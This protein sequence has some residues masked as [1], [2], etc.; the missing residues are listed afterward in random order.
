MSKQPLPNHILRLQTVPSHE[1]SVLQELLQQHEA[2]TQRLQQ[3]ERR[4][5]QLR[6]E[7][8]NEIREICLQTL[9]QLQGQSN[10]VDEILTELLALHA[11]DTEIQDAKQLQNDLTTALSQI[12]SLTQRIEALFRGEL[13]SSQIQA[14]LQEVLPSKPQ[15]THQTQP[16]PLS[17]KPHPLQRTTLDTLPESIVIEEPVPPTTQAIPTTEPPSLPEKATESSETPQ[18]STVSLFTEGTPTPKEE[19]ARQVEEAYKVRE[20]QKRE[21]KEQKREEKAQK[22]PERILRRIRVLKDRASFRTAANELIQARHQLSEQAWGELGITLAQKAN[23]ADIEQDQWQDFFQL[24]PF[25]KKAALSEPKLPEISKSQEIELTSMIARLKDFSFRLDVNVQ[26]D[27]PDRQAFLDKLTKILQH[28]A[29]APSDQRLLDIVEPFYVWIETGKPFRSLRRHL[30]EPQAENGL[31][32]T[33]QN[34]ASPLK[35]PEETGPCASKPN[36]TPKDDPPNAPLDQ[37][38]QETVKPSSRKRLKKEQKKQDK[39]DKQDKKKQRLLENLLHPEPNIPEGPSI[40][41]MSPED[42]LFELQHLLSGKRAAMIG[43]DPREQRRKALEDK[44]GFQHL[45]WIQ[46]ENSSSTRSTQELVRRLQRGKV[47]LLILLLDFC[48]HPKAD[49]LIDTAKKIGIPFVPVMHGYGESRILQALH[50]TLA[51]N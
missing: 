9:A 24:K 1:S 3:L 33:L 7:K 32:A 31:A 44:L 45:D 5:Q 29:S 49:A 23:A 51:S 35:I 17:N 46:S 22:A 40:Q 26:I 12:S 18:G 11:P 28:P 42:L 20:E 14:L 50:R 30:T 6:Q 27:H 47:D 36:A 10:Q 13:S 19:Y 16:L 37:E 21:E 39:Q 15:P 2:L 4:R 34:T 43:G 25:L 38:Q 8:L 48:G 41:Q